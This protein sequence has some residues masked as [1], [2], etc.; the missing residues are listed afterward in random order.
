MNRLIFNKV[1]EEFITE[2]KEEFDK[3]FQKKIEGIYQGKMI[4]GTN[5]SL[6]NVLEDKFTN[7]LMKLFGD[8]KYLY[9]IDVSFSTKLLGEPKASTIRP[10]IVI[11]NR[12]SREIK[13]VFEVKIDDARADDYWVDNALVRLQRL[14]DISQSFS[15]DSYITFKTIKVNEEGE[16]IRVKRKNSEERVLVFDKHF[17]TCDPKAQIACIVLCKENSRKKKSGGDRTDGD[18]GVYISKKHLNNQNYLLSDFLGK[19]EN[20]QPNID[21]DKLFKVINKMNIH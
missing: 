4:R 17:L 3:V 11:I 15:E 13:A 18:F 8:E 1:L 7:F 6:G 16:P 9:L 2:M 5:P 20:D 12:Q 19:D 21:Y 14:K 10:D